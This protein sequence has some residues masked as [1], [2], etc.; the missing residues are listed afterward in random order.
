MKRKKKKLPRNE[1]NNEIHRGL[2]QDSDNPEWGE[3]D[4]ARGRSA[5][6]VLPE[7]LGEEKADSLFKRGAGRPPKENPKKR[8]TVRLD[9][10]VV[11]WIKEQGPGYQTRI[12]EILREAMERH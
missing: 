10:D 2:E 3:E 12:N 11:E 6:E 7:I 4:F 8:I 1:E 5:Q 9:A